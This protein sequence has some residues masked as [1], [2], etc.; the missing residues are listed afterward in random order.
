MREL[1]KSIFGLAC[2][3]FALAAAPASAQVVINEID[4]DNIG[5]DT[6]EFIELFNA[7]ASP[8]NISGHAVGLINGATDTFYTL[9][10]IPA[11]TT[12][13]PGAYYVIGSTNVVGAN[14]NF[15]GTTDQIQNGAPDAVGLYLDNTGLMSGAPATSGGVLLDGIIYE[16]P[17]TGA[18]HP[19]YA[20]STAADSNVTNISFGRFPNGAGPFAIL[21]AP[22]PGAAN[23]SSVPEPTSL[24]LVAVA[25][26]AQL[27]I[28]RRRA[29]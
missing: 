25:V 2:A 29:R 23:F 15:V 27:L 19:G 3:A 28:C 9:V 22:S 17:E 10:T 14:Q 7:G 11:A 1:R 13:A 12:L 6:T 8:V 20:Q 26:G 5:T 16:G 21:D 24:G 4:Y 18:Y